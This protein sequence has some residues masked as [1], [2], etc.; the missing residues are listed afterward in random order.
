MYQWRY[1][2]RF[3]TCNSYL[4]ESHRILSTLIKTIKMAILR[5]STKRANCRNGSDSVGRTQLSHTMAS[6]RTGLFFGNESNGSEKCVVAAKC[7][8]RGPLWNDKTIRLQFLEKPYVLILVL[9]PCH[10]ASWW[11]M[12]SLRW[13]R[14]FSWSFWTRNVTSIGLW[15]SKEGTIAS[16]RHSE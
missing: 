12:L 4:F 3:P 16:K 5:L 15:R 2:L 13:Q 10:S 1:F 8:L 6:Y 11:K 9:S 7:S 14:R